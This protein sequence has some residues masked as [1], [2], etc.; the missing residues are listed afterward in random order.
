MNI[1]GKSSKCCSKCKF[2]GQPHNFP[3]Y[4]NRMECQGTVQSFNY[5]INW[6]SHTSFSFNSSP[7]VEGFGKQEAV[8]WNFDA[9]RNYHPGNCGLGPFGR[10]DTRRGE[11]SDVR[12]GDSF[13][14]LMTCSWLSDSKWKSLNS[15]TQLISGNQWMPPWWHINSSAL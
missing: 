14:S 8:S 9:S 2:C 7:D 5:I 4:Y 15:I 13:V 12:Q 11:I 6:L 1:A 3:M 10:G